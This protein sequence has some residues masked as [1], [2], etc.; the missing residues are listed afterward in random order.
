MPDLKENF[1]VLLRGVKDFTTFVFEK[2]IQRCQIEAVR[3][4]QH[5]HHRHLG[6]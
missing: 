2:L 3:H 6:P 1:K 4:D 5:P